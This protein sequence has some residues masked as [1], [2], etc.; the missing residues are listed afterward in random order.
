MSV[1]LI[2]SKHQLHK[3]LQK[4]EK[5]TSTFQAISFQCSVGVRILGE[6]LS[7]KVPSSI[8]LKRGW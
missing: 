8:G 6:N 3:Q 7:M 5:I 1:F 4:L 2:F